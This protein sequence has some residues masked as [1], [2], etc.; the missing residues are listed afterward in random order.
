[1]DHYTGNG[2]FNFQV[3]LQAV[4]GDSCLH[5]LLNVPIPPLAVM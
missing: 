5:C 3:S 2:M 1:M 4:H